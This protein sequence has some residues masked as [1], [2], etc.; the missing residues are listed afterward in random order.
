MAH[1]GR[2]SSRAWGITFPTPPK[3]PCPQVA[4]SL[5]AMASKRASVIRAKEKASSKVVGIALNSSICTVDCK[6]AKQSIIATSSTKVEYMVASKDS[7]EFFWIRKFIFGLSVVPTNEEPMKM[8]CDNT[9]AITVANEPGIT[10]GAKNYRTKVDYLREVIELGNIV[11]DKVHTNNNVVDPFT[12]VFPF[13]NH[14]SHTKS[15]CLL[16]ASSRAAIKP[17]FYQATRAWA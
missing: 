9:R 4:F 5:C 10:K 7:K 15:I 12:K 17:R 13:N 2:P 6:R 14:S 1:L 8:Y 11:P 3:P 16:L